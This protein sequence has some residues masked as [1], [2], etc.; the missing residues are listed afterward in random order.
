MLLAFDDMFLYGEGL[1]APCPVPKLEIQ[2]L[3]AL[4]CHFFEYSRS[5]QP[6]LTIHNSR[7]DLGPPG[8][9][10]TNLGVVILSDAYRL[11]L[12]T[13]TSSRVRAKG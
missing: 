1:F 6:F 7:T 8:P 13:A 2:L 12:A 11:S 5:Y 4:G 9:G 3:S 10:K